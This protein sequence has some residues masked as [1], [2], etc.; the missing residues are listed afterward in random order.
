[1]GKGSAGGP[2]NAPP[3]PGRGSGAKGVGKTERKGPWAPPGYGSYDAGTEIRLAAIELFAGLRTTH[4]AA[5]SVHNLSIVL[6]H[7]A[8]KCPFANHLARKNG[9]QEKLFLDVANLNDQWASDFVDEAE[10]LQAHAILII[11]GF[12]CKG[13]S[14]Q[15][16]DKRPNLKDKHSGLFYHIPRVAA[17]W[18]PVACG[19]ES[20][21]RMLSCRKPLRTKSRRN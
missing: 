12:P 7:A 8:E 20:S 13:L 21:S 10:K 3:P 5:K 4:V 2:T 16:G 11:G 14:R 1:M 15:R 18:P 17:R 19:S 6:S 9:I